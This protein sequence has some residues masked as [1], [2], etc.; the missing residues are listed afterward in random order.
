MVQREVAERIV[1]TPGGRRMG[2]LSVFCQFFG[3]PVILFHVPP[4]AFFPK[5]KVDS[6]VFQIASVRDPETCLAR[7]HWERFF[8]FVDRCFQ[9]RRKMLANT[10]DENKARARE[11]MHK[12]DIDPSSRPEALSVDQWLRLYAVHCEAL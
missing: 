2:F 8:S 9:Q 3:T 5:P 12:A 7:G 1:A 11:Q 4:G 10:V 6:S